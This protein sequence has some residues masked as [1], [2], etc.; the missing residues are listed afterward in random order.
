MATISSY[1]KPAYL[2]NTSPTLQQP[3]TT[4]L[5][6][7]P[8]QPT[9]GFNPGSLRRMQAEKQKELGNRFLQLR[10]ND[11]AVYH[12]MIAIQLDPGYTD[13]YYNLARTYMEMNDRPRA[14]A[15]FEKLLQIDPQD[16]DARSVL[17]ETLTEMGHWQAA[18]DHYTYILQQL[19]HFD[20]ASR[21]LKYVQHMAAAQQNGKQALSLLQVEGKQTLQ[22]ALAMVQQYYTEQGQAYKLR[23]LHEKGHFEFSPTQ[24]V[25]QVANMAEYD[26]GQSVIR[27]RMELAFASPNVLAAYIVH[28]LTHFFDQDGISSVM[29]EQ[30]AY[31]DLARFW[32]RNKGQ[33]IEPNLDLAYNLWQQSPDKLDKKVRELYLLREPLLPEKSP[34]HGIPYQHVG[35]HFLEQYE[36]EK[37][38]KYIDFLY[39]RMKQLLPN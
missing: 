12:Y 31:R 37:R 10:L 36:E 19:P 14:I 35:E 38:N 39:E 33:T 13:P 21:N 24:Q 3:A 22:K 5:T 2:Q 23:T 27:I 17:A 1:P 7:P 25:N 26:H 16:H 29:E 9:H 18:V 28:E 34:G 11:Q 8:S 15:T 30:N 6:Q 32:G 20:V 4:T